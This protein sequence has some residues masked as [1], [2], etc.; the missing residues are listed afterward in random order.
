MG[1]LSKLG[2]AVA[3]AWLV[4]A[5]VALADTTTHST[6]QN[7][8]TTSQPCPKGMVKGPDGVCV[9]P[10]GGRMGF[11]LA[12]PSDS[13]SSSS[14]SSSTSGTRSV[15]TTNPSNKGSHKG[16]NKSSNKGSGNN[17]NKNSNNKSPTSN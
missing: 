6:N 2:A 4:Q 3:C 12:G 8:Q 14:S 9:H 11:D 17:T 16:G 7:T 5:G 15:G 13:D 10:K 1:A